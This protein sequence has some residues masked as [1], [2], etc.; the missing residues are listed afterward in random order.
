MKNAQKSW[1][2]DGTA[3]RLKTDNSLSDATVRRRMRSDARRWAKQGLTFPGVDFELAS[4]R[5]A[6]GSWRAT[7]TGQGYVLFAVLDDVAAGACE[8]LLHASQAAWSS[9]DTDKAT[10]SHLNLIEVAIEVAEAAH[11]RLREAAPALYDAWDDLALLDPGTPREEIDAWI[12]AAMH[13]PAAAYHLGFA[14]AV[15]LQR[16]ELQAVTGR[17][18]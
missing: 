7:I 6:D 14:Q 16:I 2:V 8:A 11:E 10:R 13:E 1:A 9:P 5:H 18:L 17:D 15:I 4:E 12:A 3:H